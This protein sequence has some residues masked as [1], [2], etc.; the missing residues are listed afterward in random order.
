MRLGTSIVAA[1]IAA[2][3]VSSHASAETIY[4]SDDLNNLYTFDSATPG[5]PVKVAITGLATGETLIGIDVRPATGALYGIGTTNRV[6]TINPATG[7][8]TGVGPGG[9]FTTSGAR[10]GFDFN[11]IP[12]R[13]RV[14]SSTGQSLRINPNDGS[15]GG[16]DT[17]LN[18]GSPSV[19]AA[20]Y[21]RNFPR[22]GP[23]ATDLTPTTLFGIDNLA[24]TLVRIGGVDGSP[25][26]NAG[27]VTTIG[28]LGLGASLNDEIN[29]DISGSG[30][31]YASFFNGGFGS[32]N[33]YTINLGTGLATLVGTVGNGGVGAPPTLT[34]LAAATVPEPTSMFIL[35][36][37][38]IGG[39]MRRGRR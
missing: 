14:I 20:A 26:P 4:G 24:G 1:A 17:P 25:S 29:L 36:A 39:L 33:F 9:S 16:T 18:P 38:S 23:P 5:S 37:A 7:V 15:L 31:A 22:G 19:V 28:S 21:D 11:P 35:A 27:L 34:G 2:L 10:F 13:I 6:Y 30:I 12:D 3:F 32:T 8:A